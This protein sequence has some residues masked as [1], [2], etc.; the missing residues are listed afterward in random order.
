MKY[1]ILVLLL[2]R[3]L[4]TNEI[5]VVESCHQEGANLKVN[6]GFAWSVEFPAGEYVCELYQK[7]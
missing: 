2:L 7:L 6:Y 4:E 3:H 1:L 5:E